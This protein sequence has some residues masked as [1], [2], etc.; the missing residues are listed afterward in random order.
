MGHVVE[1]LSEKIIANNR[2]NAASQSPQSDNDT[3]L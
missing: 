2:G 1:V 3:K